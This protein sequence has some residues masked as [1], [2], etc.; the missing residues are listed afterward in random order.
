LAGERPGATPANVMNTTKQVGTS[1]ARAE[2]VA[3]KKYE[4]IVLGIDWHATQY[5]VVRLIDGAGPEPP[6]R[7]TPTAFLSWAKKQLG[8]AQRV[9]CCYEAGSGG[10]V[11]HRQLSELGLLNYVVAPRS[12]DPYHKRVQNDSTDARQLALDLDRFVRGNPKAL[13]LAYVPTA[14]QEQ[15]RQPS[16]QR[17]QLAAHRLSLA[18]QGR[19]L[20]LSQGCHQSNDWWKTGRWSELAPSLPPWLLS[21][22]ETY[23]RLILAVDVEL[24]TLT[25][26]L[27]SAASRDRPAGLGALTLEQINREVCDWKRFKNRKQPGNYSGLCGGLA[28]TGDWSM[29]LPITK[30]GNVR[31]RV[32]L[33]ELAWRM[34]Y[35][36][37]QSKLIQ[38][39]AKVLLNPKAHK[40]SRKR[41]IVAVARQL[42]VQLWRWQTGQVTAQQLGWKM[43][44][45][46]ASVPAQAG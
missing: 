9:F 6:Q 39:W 29:D 32:L 16:R 41:A 28:A 11:L 36:Q 3:S 35:Y 33:I 1:E 17:Q 13:R 10:F 42:V 2:Q 37:P 5:R 21:A 4:T 7:F 30:A 22:L 45:T 25:R 8:L 46:Q 34:V 40:R 26:A 20:L 43:L 38:R 18:A 31:L 27:A 24:K 14:E 44:D 23:R 19:C 12:L 15:R